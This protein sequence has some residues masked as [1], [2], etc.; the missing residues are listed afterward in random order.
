MLTLEQVLARSMRAS[1]RR[2]SPS[3]MGLPTVR[4]GER[5]RDDDDD[6]VNNKDNKSP[7]YPTSSS[8]STISPGSIQN[9]AD[10]MSALKS[11]RMLGEWAVALELYVATAAPSSRYQPNEDHLD[12]I[13]ACCAEQ[14]KLDVVLS[15]QNSLPNASA[16]T[17]NLILSQYGKRP[18]LWCD[19]LRVVSN[20]STSTHER[21]RPNVATYNLLIASCEAS[22]KW[23]VALKI[24][25][26][27][28]AEDSTVKPDAVTYA[29]TMT[30]LESG[31]QMD[32][33][34]RLMNTMP[35]E[36]R[37]AILSSYAA[38]IQVWSVKHRVLNKSVR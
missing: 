11:A 17:I 4:T 8:T 33:V 25:N 26:S 6:D 31:H 28:E 37:S 15:W 1:S 18:G 7:N 32:H 24:L 2:S 19:A 23:D 20:M 29:A 12:E 16:E 34:Q 38:L 27:L 35:E 30:A 36:H 5:V 3:L 22:Q 14:G 13:I 21:M 10:L 9:G